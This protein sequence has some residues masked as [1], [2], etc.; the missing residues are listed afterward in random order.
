MLVRSVPLNE[1]ESW[2]WDR[3]SDLS[4][5]APQGDFHASHWH[6]AVDVHENAD[7][8]LLVADLP[9]LEQDEVDITLDKSVS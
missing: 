1:I 7:R 9:G 8:I 5:L 2:L 6:P 3:S 4:S